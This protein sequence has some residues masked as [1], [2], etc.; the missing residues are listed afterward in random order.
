MEG[1]G[2]SHD[3]VYDYNFVEHKEMNMVMTK[4]QKEW[5]K[6]DIGGRPEF[7]FEQEL[8]VGEF[9]MGIEQSMLWGQRGVD[10]TIPNQPM[11]HMEGAFHAV[12]TNVSMYNPFAADLDYEMMLQTW[13]KDQAFKYCPNG[14]TKIFLC[15]EEVIYNLT[16]SFRDTRITNGLN[17]KDNRAGLSVTEYTLPTG[18]VA[19]F[20]PTSL[21]TGD[22]AHWILAIDPKEMEL[23]VVKDYLSQFYQLPGERV[24]RY[25]CE[26]QGTIA[27]HREQSMAL[28]TTY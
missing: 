6:G 14:P 16:N 3:L 13:C 1:T 15:G 4:D 21:F 2:K 19:R 5:I 26:W 7:D 11:R 12:R 25:N 28:L 8:N 22:M 10:N 27:W 18:E 23:R 17:P 9:K 24:V 20:L